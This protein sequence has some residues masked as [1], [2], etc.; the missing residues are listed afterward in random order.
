MHEAGIGSGITAATAAEVEPKEDEVDPESEEEKEDQT[1]ALCKVL[2]SWL[3]TSNLA[4]RMHVGISKTLSAVFETQSVAECSPWRFSTWNCA[5]DTDFETR[6]YFVA[7]LP[8]FCALF[9]LLFTAFW[10][11]TL[12]MRSLKTRSWV[13]WGATWL[14]A[15]EMLLF[16]VYTL[17]SSTILSVFQCV[18]VAPGFKVLRDDLSFECSGA[19]Y[20][21]LV[22]VGYFLIVIYCIGIPL[23]I[24]CLLVWAKRRCEGGLAHPLVMSSFS[25]F[26]IDKRDEA[27]ASEILI[28]FRKLFMVAIVT[29]Y[30]GSPGYQVIIATVSL[31]FFFS[32]NMRL[33]PFKSS[34][35]TEA[36]NAS[37]FSCAISFSCCA[38]FYVQPPSDVDG[39]AADILTRLSEIFAV[40]LNT[41][42]AFAILCLICRGLVRKALSPLLSY[43]ARADGVRGEGGGGGAYE[44]PPEQQRLH[45]DG[46]GGDRSSIEMQCPV[47]MDLATPARAL[48]STV[49]H[50][51]PL[52]SRTEPHET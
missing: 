21:N 51:N 43:F 23:H 13:E 5:I 41:A 26:Y 2:V 42:V 15:T 46:G 38:L 33:K 11:G 39:E 29:L 30:S 31:W 34:M 49:Y 36:E 27:Y 37:L 45:T 10:A 12:K 44:A 6:Y 40:T 24:L 16:L 22:N 1:V 47:A 8:P 14:A 28:T 17:L 35:V 50:Q 4:L 52:N 9:S 7:A 3:Q 48:A 18:E 32:L 25:F 19:T 20:N